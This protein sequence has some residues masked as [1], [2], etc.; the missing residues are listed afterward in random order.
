MAITAFLQPGKLSLASATPSRW[1]TSAG[2]SSR[3]RCLRRRWQRHR[4]LGA[5]GSCHRFRH[6]HRSHPRFGT[7]TPGNTTAL[8]GSNV[9]SGEAYLSVLPPRHTTPDHLYL[10]I[11][12]RWNDQPDV[13]G[14]SQQLSELSMLRISNLVMTPSFLV[15]ELPVSSTTFAGGAGA[16]VIGS[17]TN[18]NNQFTAATNSALLLV[19]ISRVE[20]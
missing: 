9:V 3:P 16:D 10:R 8:S 20:W 2:P 14:V 12:Y 15:T 5:V 6:H 4:R 18:V 1:Q 19:S 11:W 17:Y 13:I 7:G